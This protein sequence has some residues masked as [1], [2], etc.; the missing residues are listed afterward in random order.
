M[1]MC[2][3]LLLHIIFEYLVK[4]FTDYTAKYTE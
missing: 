3:N 2:R 1:R 4:L